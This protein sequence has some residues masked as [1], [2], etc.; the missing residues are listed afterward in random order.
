VTRPTLEKRIVTKRPRFGTARYFCAACGYRHW[1][2]SKVGTKHK[3]EAD[4]DKERGVVPRPKRTRPPLRLHLVLKAKW[5]SLIESGEK[6]VEYRD[7]VEH[8]E[9]RILKPWNVNGGNTV[10]FHR[11]YTNVTMTF[12]LASVAV[13][14]DETTIELYLGRRI[15]GGELSLK[16]HHDL[17]EKGVWVYCSW[18]PCDKCEDQ[19]ERARTRAQGRDLL[20]RGK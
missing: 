7:F 5:F 19:R 13:T 20:E 6:T 4:F 18:C 12:N 10:T 16:E 8:W 9:T 2:W 17:A 15:D 1:Y 14:M 3:L 11:G